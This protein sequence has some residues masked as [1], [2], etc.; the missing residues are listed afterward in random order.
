M[1]L[2]CPICNKELERIDK[3]YKCLNKHTFDIA[4]QGYLNLNHSSQTG[5]DSKES[6]EARNRFLNTNYGKNCLQDLLNSNMSNMQKVQQI[7]EWW[8][9]YEEQK[10]RNEQTQ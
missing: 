3:S 8:K 1:K 7:D 4:K 10:K 2:I 5:G 6:I 9:L